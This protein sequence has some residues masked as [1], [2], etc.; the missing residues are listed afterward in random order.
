[1]KQRITVVRSLVAACLF[2]IAG[3]LGAAELVRHTVT[4][5][6]HPLAVWEKSARRCS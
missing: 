2:L 3:S 5:D 4:V 1:M 6:E